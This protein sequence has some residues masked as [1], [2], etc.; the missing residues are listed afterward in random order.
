MQTKK[1]LIL[2]VLA[3]AAVASLVY[4]IIT[5]SEARRRSSKGKKL[6]SS[7][8]AALKAIA[9]PRRPKT[10]AYISWGASPFTTAK[11]EIKKFAKISLNGIV[12]DEE[13]PRAIINDEIVAIG[14]RVSEYRIIDIKPNSVVLDDGTDEFEYV[15]G[16][17]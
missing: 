11:V 13:S 2:I 15:L 17:D 3:I 6:A 10:S 14:D 12:W 8:V 5:P 7:H 1:L 4:G 16:Q 9:Q